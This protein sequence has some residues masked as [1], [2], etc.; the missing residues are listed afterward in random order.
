MDIKG[1][2]VNIPINYTHNIVNKLLKNNRVDKCI[3]KEIMSVLMMIM[4]QNYFQYDDKFYKPKSGVALGSPLSSTMAEIFPQDL[5]QNR[6][7]HLL[8]GGKIVHYNKYVDD[9][10]IIDNQTKTTPQSLFEQ[11]NAQHKDLQLTINKEVNN[12]IA[13]LDVNLINK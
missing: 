4:N 7:K 3:L 11:F 8:E 9:I 13:Y 6:I 1:L 2:Y 5:E 10:F 12:Q